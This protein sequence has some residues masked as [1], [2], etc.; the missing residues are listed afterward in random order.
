MAEFNWFNFISFTAVFYVSCSFFFLK[1]PNFLHKKK[2]YKSKL[3]QNV[4]NSDKILHIS[5]RGGNDFFLKIHIYFI[6]KSGSREALENTL[7]AFNN[8]V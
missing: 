7:D 8:A 2:I 6:L 1:Y 4:L 3:L 5:H